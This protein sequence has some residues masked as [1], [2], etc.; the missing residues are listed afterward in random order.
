M[1]ISTGTPRAE[2]TVSE[3]NDTETISLRSSVDADKD[4]GFIQLSFIKR[5]DRWSH[6]IEWVSKSERTALLTSVEGS[7]D[8]DWPPS[9]PFQE[10]SSQNLGT[11]QALLG[12]GMAGR[13]HWSISCTTMRETEYDSILLDLAC[14]C[15]DEHRGWLGST[16]QWHSEQNS[17][18][19]SSSANGAKFDHLTLSAMGLNFQIIPSA[20]EDWATSF[21]VEE[22]LFKVSPAKISPSS[23]VATRWAFGIKLSRNRD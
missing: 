3:A 4:A 5:R 15:K 8:M 1:P 14:L 23:K 13:S 19:A 10:I 7:P 11:Q 2:K 21:G 18:D 6:R 17:K 22:N 9:P 12:V 20:G 16:Y